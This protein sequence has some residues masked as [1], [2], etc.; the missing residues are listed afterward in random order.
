M[1]LGPK[2]RRAHDKLAARPGVRSVRRPLTPDAD[3]HFDLFYVRS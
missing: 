2:R 3:D 1:T